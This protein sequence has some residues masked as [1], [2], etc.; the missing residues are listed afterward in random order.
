MNHLK[1][2]PRNEYLKL[3]K[4]CYEPEIKCDYFQMKAYFVK[5]VE[6]YEVEENKEAEET[7]QPDS[8]LIDTNEKLDDKQ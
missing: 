1:E 6:A 5:N 8:V 2:H 7:K 3:F 4:Q